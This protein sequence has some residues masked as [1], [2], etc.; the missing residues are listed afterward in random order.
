MPKLLTV[1][2]TKWVQQRS[3]DLV[4][5]DPLANPST[6]EARY[7]ARLREMIERMA[8]DVELEWL[9]FF[10]EPHAEEYFAEDAS[11]SSQA[12]IL[13]NAL[14]KK[15]NDQFA[16]AAKPIATAQLNRVDKASSSA[17]HSS[18]QQLTGGLSLQTTSL[19][20]PLTDVLQASVTENVAL[21]KSISQQY[22]SGVQGAVMR[23][24]TTGR[25]LADLVPFLAK[26][27]GITDRRA[28]MIARD[29][30]R[31]AY[32]ALNKGRM[33]AVGLTHFM[34]LH[35]GGSSHPRKLHIEHSGKVFSF[36]DP[37]LIDENSGEHGIPGQ[38]INC[39]CRMT[40]VLA[41][42]D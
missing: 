42:K 3:P 34:W 15:F 28:R 13:A 16:A 22:L 23:S 17:L 41:L 25:G 35:T 4:R 26:H 9:K 6:A 11:I 8:G 36:D 19:A 31:K 40:P 14:S 18:M 38:A 2:K 7:Y 21:I 30:T 37:P 1:R 10:D 29:Q 24:I 32:N 20:G 27:K 5:G 33:Q 39:R 12:R